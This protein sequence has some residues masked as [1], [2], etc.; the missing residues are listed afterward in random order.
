MRRDIVRSSPVLLLLCLCVIFI[1]YGEAK[2]ALPKDYQE[3]MARY[4]REATTPEGALK[5]YFEAVFCFIDE[6][7]RAEGAKMLRYAMHFDRPT[8]P[9]FAAA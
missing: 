1:S 9:S 4:Q 5:L 6:G 8:M 3:F 2:A 7:T